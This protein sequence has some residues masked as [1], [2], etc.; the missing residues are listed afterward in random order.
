MRCISKK[1]FVFIVPNKITLIKCNY[2]K[3]K[4]NVENKLNIIDI[5][6]NIVIDINIQ[7][8]IKNLKNPIVNMKR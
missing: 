1:K 6:E 8:C 5:N 3:H 2:N 7:R 4:H